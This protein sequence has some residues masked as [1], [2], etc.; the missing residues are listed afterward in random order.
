MLV[1]PTIL[2]PHPIVTACN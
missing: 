2:D 1:P